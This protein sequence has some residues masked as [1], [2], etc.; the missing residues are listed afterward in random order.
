MKMKC[1]VCGATVEFKPPR[2]WNLKAGL[3]V[4]HS[5]DDTHKAYLNPTGSYTGS[6]QLAAINS[7]LMRMRGD[8]YVHGRD[9]SDVCTCWI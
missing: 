4:V 1:D 2:G 3:V 9:C 7:D 6:C 5:I 8:F